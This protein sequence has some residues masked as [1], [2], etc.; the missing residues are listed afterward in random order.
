MMK[1]KIR[2]AVVSGRCWYMVVGKRWL[3][4]VVWEGFRM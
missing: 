1:Y 3:W 2:E 4:F